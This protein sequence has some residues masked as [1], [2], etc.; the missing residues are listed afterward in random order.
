RILGEKTNAWSFQTCPRAASCIEQFFD[1]WMLFTVCETAIDPRAGRFYVPVID[2]A[3]VQH[4]IALRTK[5]PIKGGTQ[6]SPWAKASVKSRMRC[7]L[8]PLNPD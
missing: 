4:E 6:R 7:V 3:P 5:A 8:F 1:A 2:D